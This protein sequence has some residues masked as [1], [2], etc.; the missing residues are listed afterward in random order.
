L[1]S[2]YRL[3]PLL[4]LDWNSLLP[5]L[6]VSI[7]Y[8][9]CC[10]C[11]HLCRSD[12][13][14]TVEQSNFPL[15]IKSPLQFQH[16]TVPPYHVPRLTLLP[17]RSKTRSLSA[18]RL[19]SWLF[20]LALTALLLGFALDIQRLHEQVDRI[21]LTFD[22]FESSQPIASGSPSV[23]TL[24]FTH[25]FPKPSGTVPE[26][27]PPPASPITSPTPSPNPDP[28]HHD[29]APSSGSYFPFPDGAFDDLPNMVHIPVTTISLTT[30]FEP[31]PSNI[32]SR[33]TNHGMAGSLGALL[34][35]P[36]R[37]PIAYLLQFASPKFLIRKAWNLVIL[38][39]HVPL[40][41]L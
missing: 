39:F 34:I 21:S 5:I 18:G 4:Y 26:P 40:E 30:T 8:F 24:E 1:K 11:L 33:N 22:N 3:S 38:L 6:R 35:D 23:P 41:P 20:I 29:S 15:T 36:L 25:D 27:P 2:Y 31:S 7:G 12:Y 37:N 10:G 16:F 17:K 9:I 28:E 13:H 19:A 14:L 32:Y